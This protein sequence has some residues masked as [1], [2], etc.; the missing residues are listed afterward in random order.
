MSSDNAKTTDAVTKL[1]S[2][3]SPEAT[4]TTTSVEQEKPR[5]LLKRAADYFF[6]GS[7][8]SQKKKA[9]L[10]PSVPADHGTNHDTKERVQV[11]SANHASTSTAAAV[12][13]T[14]ASD[15][16]WV[17]PLA[18][19]SNVAHRES[20]NTFSSKEDA[21]ASREETV[22]GNHPSSPRELHLKHSLHGRQVNSS[23]KSHVPSTT[24]HDVSFSSRED[25]P[26]FSIGS[27]SSSKLTLK[28]GSTPA[29]NRRK[30]QFASSVKPAP[31]HGSR[32]R[33][34]IGTPYHDGH[35]RRPITTTTTT[36]LGSSFSSSSTTTTS[37]ALL[38]SS[39]WTSQRVRNVTF[40]SNIPLSDSTMGRRQYYKTPIKKSL[41]EYHDKEEEEE[42]EEGVAKENLPGSVQQQRFSGQK[43]KYKATSRILS[44]P[45]GVSLS[46]PTPSSAS[47][48]SCISA[49]TISMVASKILEKQASRFSP[50]TSSGDSTL[51]RDPTAVQVMGV[52][53]VYGSHQ[54]G[55]RVES[56][57]AYA[58]VDKDKDTDTDTDGK[59][60][61]IQNV[62]DVNGEQVGYGWR[63][64]QEVA[65]EVELQSQTQQQRP[66]KRN[67]VTFAD[68]RSQDEAVDDAMEGTE[69]QHVEQKRMPREFTPYKALPEKVFVAM[70][71][72][73][74][75]KRDD[76]GKA[77]YPSEY[78]YGVKMEI[79]CGSIGAL[80][81]DVTKK[82]L[83]K[84]KNGSL[85]GHV[86]FSKKKKVTNSPQMTKMRM[87]TNNNGN[88]SNVPYDFM[89]KV[90]SN[91]RKGSSSIL[92]KPLSE[93]LAGSEANE[94]ASGTTT[95][96][97]ENTI[98]GTTKPT[99]SVASTESTAPSNTSTTNGW[100]N[101]FASEAGTWKC[102]VCC[103]KNKKEASKCAACETP[104]PISGDENKTSS[105][106]SNVSSTSAG[107]A[108]S[109]GGTQ[110]NSSQTKASTTSV[111]T[112]GA[113]NSTKKDG[114]NDTSSAKFSFGDAGNA[115]KPS[116]GGF[117]FGSNN[118]KSVDEK[119]TETGAKGGFVFGLSSKPDEKSVNGAST[120]DRAS[121]EKGTA[122]PA[123]GSFSFSS[124]A[125][126]T[127]TG[128]EGS[129]GTF[130]FGKRSKAGT[131]SEISS[132]KSSVEGFTFGSAANAASGGNNPVGNEKRNTGGFSFGGKNNDSGVSSDKA[133]EVN[134]AAGFSFGAATSI[135]PSPAE[136]ASEQT[137]VGTFSFGETAMSGAS[138]H[139]K[140][141]VQPSTG[142]FSFGSA[143]KQSEKDG[144]NSKK[145]AFTFGSSALAPV[146]EAKSYSSD[147]NVGVS[148]LPAFNEQKETVSSDLGATKSIESSAT[149][150]EKNE[151]NTS[152]SGF[153]FGSALASRG[154]E[155]KD[156]SVPKPQFSF[157]G[158][159]AIPLSSGGSTTDKAFGSSASKPMLAFGSVQSTDK[160]ESTKTTSFGED[161]THVK[162]RTVDDAISK[163]APPPKFTFCSSSGSA[164]VSSSQSFAFGMNKDSAVTAA[165][166]SKP[167]F[168]F[169]SSGT[170][171][172]V[173]AP[174]PSSGFAFG[175]SAPSAPAT[176]STMET[177]APAPTAGFSFGSTPVP[178][179]G[180]T[181]TF[182]SA[183]AP[184]TTAASSSFSFGSNN[185]PA[186]PPVP[187]GAPSTMPPP[188]TVGGFSFG[189]SQGM[190]AAP[191]G[192]P[193]AT[194]AFRGGFGTNTPS[195]STA[196]SATLSNFGAPNGQPNM[197]LGGAPVPGGG[198]SI[199]TGGGG[200]KNKG[201]R[202]I[203]RA[204]RPSAR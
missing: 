19:D 85:H 33:M 31:V 121:G 164:P 59:D 35:R 43:K 45:A 73:V 12:A 29:L 171:S 5:S 180:S 173:S 80:E 34:R 197:M 48:L 46:G 181:F 99:L 49:Q 184:A 4:M 133:Q 69:I 176:T 86:K 11:T 64:Q 132:E 117:V 55:S 195:T 141:D 20:G 14:A 37:P 151:V 118:S 150:E 136:K 100:G 129:K 109:F 81:S 90:V 65:R 52:K 107:V 112:F 135:S 39:R 178:S 104:K 89:P 60:A 166:E 179:Q 177:Q 159:A 68:I 125:N 105:Q 2:P 57:A 162:K 40:S 128:D 25:F 163:T 111:F 169:G 172:P 58:D 84:L 113:S 140:S 51:F 67:R 71:N 8:S 24:N 97:N 79:G 114:G 200:N 76:Q 165:T 32:E 93:V 131:I 196:P 158:A 152:K 92:N 74:D 127:T 116:T 21:S 28:R 72:D 142:G 194:S 110:S 168:A 187:F 126:A 161:G 139:V 186:Q 138:D 193:P 137:T 170:S 9:K 199:G 87:A 98:G 175:S 6:F 182:G 13:G 190:A 75:Y 189:Q 15:H 103:V 88:M 145:R 91:S 30:I 101:L 82:A 62:Q 185:G 154:G 36:T 130:N 7:A 143:A 18:R 61:S 122:Q 70:S 108:F 77:T 124:T 183:P 3:S 63:R 134:A 188:S 96:L 47:K 202:R 204:K 23:S 167:L 192:Q 146:S 106:L 119:P 156:E 44:L 78:V 198:F 94:S 27:G 54:T 66:T 41:D 50:K 1:S 56:I 153:T 17:S 147:F 203:I 115:V 149:T 95:K 148:S 174:A 53:R 155:K 16:S 42:Q 120:K 201:G 38:G 26:S 102:D 22:A 157:G 160:A 123:T 144:E 83:E 10:S 191:F